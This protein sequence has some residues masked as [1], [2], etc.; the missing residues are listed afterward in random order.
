MK[1]HRWMSRG[2]RRGEIDDTVIC[3]LLTRARAS[4]FDAYVMPQ[5]ADLP[6]ANRREDLLFSRP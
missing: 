4:G 3:A 6:M 2:I 5:A 1:I